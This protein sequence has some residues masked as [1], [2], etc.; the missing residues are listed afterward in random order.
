MNRLTR[1]LLVG[2]GAL[3]LAAP[4]L[5]TDPAQVI[6]PAR[7]DLHPRPKVACGHVI[8]RMTHHLNVPF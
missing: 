7:S 8:Q 3:A 5:A 2:A 1:N 4:T 6:R